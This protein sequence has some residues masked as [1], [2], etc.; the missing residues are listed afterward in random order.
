M[1]GVRRVHG[2]QIGYLVDDQSARLSQLQSSKFELRIENTLNNAVAGIIKVLACQS[3]KDLRKIA[4][5]RNRNHF[6]DCRSDCQAFR[7]NSCTS[8]PLEF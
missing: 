6:R 3:L 7:C 4:N 5:S 8:R 2:V 1:Y